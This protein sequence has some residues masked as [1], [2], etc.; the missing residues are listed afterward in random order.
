MLLQNHWSVLLCKMFIFPSCFIIVG[1]CCL[2]SYTRCWSHKNA[3]N[4]KNSSFIFIQTIHFM[5]VLLLIKA[6]IKEKYLQSACVFIV[7]LKTRYE[8]FFC[9]NKSIICLIF[10]LF[11]RNIFIFLFCSIIVFD[12]WLQKQKRFPLVD[13][14]C[15]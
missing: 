9:S 15:K 7:H 4:F 2:F 12:Y 5:K 1:C 3:I 6:L 14:K 13:R 10:K 8:H 11:Y